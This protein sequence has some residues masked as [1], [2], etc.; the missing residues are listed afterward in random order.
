MA[1]TVIHVLSSNGLTGMY[2]RL[3]PLGGLSLTAELALT[4]TAVAGI[5]TCTY[6]GSEAGEYLVALAD[7]TVAGGG[8]V[9]QWDFL[10]LQDVAG[11]LV[12]GR[13]PGDWLTLSEIVAQLQTPGVSVGFGSGIGLIEGDH[14]S[15]AIT[16]L[17]DLTGMTEL[18]FM[19]KESDAI[20]GPDSDA[21][22]HISN[23]ADLVRINKDAPSA[24]T[25]GTMTIDD[26][27]NG[28]ITL[29]LLPVE[30]D[31]LLESSDLTYAV[32]IIRPSGITAQELRRGAF[33]ITAGLVEETP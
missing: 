33:T 24:G 15:Q 18:I 5:Y 22:I 3:Y 10:S 32:K 30:S 16:G 27:A 2:A 1:S 6:T 12:A 25:N 23:T 29:A 13:L 17:G 7:D 9:L 31:K 14:W 26:T 28:N 19:V 8:N 11:P 4:E 21:I 20:D